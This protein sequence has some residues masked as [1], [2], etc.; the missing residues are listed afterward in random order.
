MT[1]KI[2]MATQAVFETIIL[3]GHLDVTDVAMETKGQFNSPSFLRLVASL[4]MLYVVMETNTITIK[5]NQLKIYLVAKC[6]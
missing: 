5:V 1:Q 3:H 2:K 6:I 4:I